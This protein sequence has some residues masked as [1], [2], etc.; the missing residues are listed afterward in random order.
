MNFQHTIPK[1]MSF[2]LIVISGI[3]NGFIARLKLVKLK[4]KP[5]TAK[6]K[7]STKLNMGHLMSKLFMV[8]S[9]LQHTWVTLSS[10]YTVYSTHSLFLCLAPLCDNSFPGQ[11]SCHAEISIILV[12]TLDFR[13]HFLTASCSSLLGSL[14][15][16]CTLATYCL[17]LVIFG[18]LDGWFQ[19]S[20]ILISLFLFCL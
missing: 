9:G 8:S 2:C 18:N 5:S 6:T 17:D 11:T 7:P 20:V 3:M 19:D 10:I 13:I 14:S 1:K 12:L 4:S 15:R 16:K